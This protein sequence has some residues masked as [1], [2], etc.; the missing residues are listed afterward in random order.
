MGVSYLEPIVSGQEV[1]DAQRYDLSTEQDLIDS[2]ILGSQALLYNAG[3]WKPDNPLTKAVVHLIV[4]HWLENR[5]LMGVDYKSI[6]ALPIGITAII[7]SLRF[8]GDDN[9]E[10][11]KNI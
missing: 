1:A 5:D 3:A 4:G 8:W 6:D 10:A 9:G 11:R 2:L 7:N